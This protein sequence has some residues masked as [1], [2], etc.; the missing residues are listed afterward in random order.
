[1]VVVPDDIA[2]VGFDN[3]EQAEHAATPISG[4]KDAVGLASGMAVDRLMRRA[5]G[6]ARDDG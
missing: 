4:V 5:S 2:I 6:A 1:L 3:I